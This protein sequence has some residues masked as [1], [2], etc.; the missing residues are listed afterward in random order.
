VPE[1][2]DEFRYPVVALPDSAMSP[3]AIVKFLVEHLVK[4]G[5]LQSK[6]ADQVVCQV[7]RRESQGSTNVGRGFAL[8]HSKSNAVKEVLGVFG[9]STIP[10]AWPG[11]ADSEPVHVVCL[12]VTPALETVAKH[13]RSQ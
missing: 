9:R 10:V 2:T 11:P 7:L 13:L 5:R 6:L 4:L 12:L 8:P 3:D 1:S